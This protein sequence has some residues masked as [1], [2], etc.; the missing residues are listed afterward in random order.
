MKTDNK[1]FIEIS[2]FLVM[3]L[4]ICAG[5]S[6][7]KERKY[8]LEELDNLAQ[9]EIY[10]A[11]NDELIKVIDDEEMLYQHNQC[12]TDASYSEEEQEELEKSLEGIAQD[13][14]LITYKYP[15]ARFGKGEL[16]KIT[17]VTIYENSNI[18]KMTVADE[19]IKAFSIP[20]EFLTFYYEVSDEDMEFYRSMIEEY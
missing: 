2:I 3:V 19:S 16:E 20:Q 8:T 17:T 15:V 7:N 14:Y 5:C 9:I 18:V 1:K 11:E 6:M 10:S 12:F 13:Y 4:C